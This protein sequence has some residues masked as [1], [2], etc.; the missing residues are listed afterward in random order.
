MNSLIDSSTKTIIG[1]K[2]SFGYEGDDLV[3][4]YSNVRFY[5][6]GSLIVKNTM[7]Y[8]VDK[9]NN[10][11]RKIDVSNKIVST[12]SGGFINHPYGEDLPRFEISQVNV[13][14]KPFIYN[15]ELYFV[16]QHLIIRKVSKIDGLIKTVFGVSSK[17]KTETSPT[18]T[19]KSILS[20]FCF[21]NGDLVISGYHDLH[22]LNLDTLRMRYFQINYSNPISSI[23]GFGNSFDN[24]TMYIGFVSSD[25]IYK[26]QNETLQD[27]SKIEYSVNEFSILNNTL[28]YISSGILIKVEWKNQSSDWIE[29]PVS[30][31]RVAYDSIYGKIYVANGYRIYEANLDD[32][33]LRKVGGIDGGTYSGTYVDF[34][35]Y[36]GEN[37]NATQSAMSIN[38]IY[39]HNG[40][41]YIATVSSYIYTIV[42]GIAK[43]IVGSNPSS[44]LLGM[45]MN[46]FCRD[47]NQN[48]IYIIDK[49]VLKKYDEK[50]GEITSL[51]PAVK[52]FLSFSLVLL[53]SFM[54]ALFPRVDVKMVFSLYDNM[55]Y[56]ADY[57]R[58]IQIDPK[59]L[60]YQK[61]AG[62]ECGTV[63]PDIPALN[64]PLGKQSTKGLSVNPKN[65]DIYI[66]Y[67]DF[68]GKIEKSSG[69]I[70]VFFWNPLN[71][72]FES[73]DGIIVENDKR[74][75]VIG[76]SHSISDD[77]HYFCT[78]NTIRVLER[79][80]NGSFYL[81]SIVGTGT[82][83]YSGDN[84]PAVS[85]KLSQIKSF[86]VKENGD[87]II[88]D[89]GNN[90]IRKYVKKTGLLVT[91]A[92]KPREQSTYFNGDLKGVET[93]FIG[94]GY[95]IDVNEKSDETLFLETVSTNGVTS[96]IRKLYPVCE[97]GAQFNSFNNTCDC[98][99]GFYGDK[100]QPITCNGTSSSDSKSCNGKGSCVGLDICN[101]ITGFDG[102]FC[103]R[104]SLD[105]LANDQSTTV[106]VV[107]I[108]IPIVGIGLIIVIIV[109]VV[110]ILLSM[111]KKKAVKRNEIANAT[112]VEMSDFPSSSVIISSS[113][114]SNV[115]DNE[116]VLSR[117]I[118]MVRIGQG[119]F[120]S[121]FKVTDTKCGNKIKAV[122]FV[123]FES[124]TD[125]NTIM[126]E[127]SQFSNIRHPNI[128]IINDYFITKDNLLCMDMD[129]FENGDLTRFTKKETCSEDI[130]RKIM[131][132]VLS[133]LDYVHSELS[134]IHRDIKPS[135][136]FIRNLSGNDIE[137]VLADFGLA[138]KHQEMKGHS[139]A[140]TPLFMS[141]E[142]ALGSCYSFNT[143]IF[144]L[145]VSIYQIM[146]KDETIS[147]GNLLMGNQSANAVS[148]LTKQMEAEQQ[149]SNEL[150]EIVIKMLD[151]NQE[152]RPSARQIL[153]MPYFK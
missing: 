17:L 19:F 126:K 4:S 56:V 102:Q 101:C 65:G 34:D 90:I 73:E 142:I 127:A 118:N 147:I 72:P 146:T 94:F 44:N 13:L 153:Q 89:S 88:L 64:S 83:G 121:V 21:P 78:A 109:V 77:L 130:I 125:L 79:L 132:Q 49:N 16:E 148:I 42:D 80:Q 124:F 27:S 18:R 123:K 82:D 1:E 50:T 112:I 119:A 48:L 93:S 59:T 47:P 25:G 60:K 137:V 37:V 135:N 116:D 63:I 150:M 122:K 95:T 152:T 141:P 74:I 144:S 97:G 51:L 103:E 91:I 100:C 22:V 54:F 86:Y 61:V 120:G 128:L 138:K 143:D 32:L 33:S 7:V 2:D 29:F 31:S 70:R 12:F 69:M 129:Y 45:D 62:K 81:K 23:T 87:I 96:L 134:I 107:A 35:G 8:L 131:K 24:G 108:V 110:I 99:S 38:S 9:S 114:G 11:I 71:S 58:I 43:T 68:F 57:C 111:K 84:L 66:C 104:S 39:A 55:I 76:S 136:I 3:N 149:Y 133:A 113:M 151:R 67:P 26:Y 85:S 92:G 52:P 20:L 145:G 6:P 75:G 117:Y 15:D 28:Y 46:S 53:D 139:Y 115:S 41:I 10:C 105:N 5:E 36:S 140:G 106:L 14:Y 30:I 40:V 98:L